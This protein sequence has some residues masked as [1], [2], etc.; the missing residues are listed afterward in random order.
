M[1]D[2]FKVLSDENRLK[3]VKMMIQQGEVCVC[4]FEEVLG[5]KQANCSKHLQKMKE[6]KIV[7]DRREGKYSH[8]RLNEEFVN[9]NQL[10]INYIKE[11]L[12]DID[13]AGGCCNV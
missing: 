5:C 1:H 7:V 8:Y 3:M 9:E 2:I 10:L 11:K 12:D 6:Y 4:D 13:L